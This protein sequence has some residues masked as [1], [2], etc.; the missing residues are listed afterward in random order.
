MLFLG[1]IF[2]L[3]V[4]STTSNKR[5][6]QSNTI[7]QSMSKKYSWP[8]FNLSPCFNLIETIANNEIKL[9]VETMANL[10]KINHIWS[11]HTGLKIPNI[12]PLYGMR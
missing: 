1:Y 4:I 11:T 8:F 3:E 9:Q 12:L 6:L 2:H 10:S 5:Q 7:G